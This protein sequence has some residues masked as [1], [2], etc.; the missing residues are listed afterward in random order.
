[1]K[2]PKIDPMFVACVKEDI[3]EGETVTI[4]VR[5]EDDIPAWEE[6]FTDEELDSITFVVREPAAVPGRKAP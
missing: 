4:L 6:R 1:V 3:E 5:S 2:R